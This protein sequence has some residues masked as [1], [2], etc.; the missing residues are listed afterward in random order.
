[1]S[2]ALPQYWWILAITTVAFCLSAFGNGA[3]DVANAFATSVAAR[4]LTMAQAGVI[5]VIAEFLGAVVLGSR[6]TNTIKN[7]IIGLDRFRDNPATLLVAMGSAEIASATWLLVATKIGFPVSTTH[8]IVGALVGAGIGA[9]SAVTWEWKKG[10][11]SQIAASWLISPLIAA[12]FS[13]ILFGTLKFCVL[14]RKD[15]FKKALRAIPFYLAF[16][17]AI[18]ALFITIEAPGA[19]SLEE[20]GVGVACGI[21]FGAFFGVLALSYLFFM[22][23]F[24]RVVVLEDDRMRPWHLPLGPLLWRENPPLYFPGKTTMLVDHYESAHNKETATGTQPSASS[25]KASATDAET[26][27]PNSQG[28]KDVE[29]EGQVTRDIERQPEEPAVR[30]APR[31]PEPEERFL[32][33]TAHLPFYHPRRMKS[34]ILYFL[35]QGVTRDCVIHDSLHLENVHGRAP[36]YDNRIE[37][38]WTYAQVASAVMMSIS[39]GSNDVANAVG[40]WVAVYE[41]YNSG[42]VGEENPTPVW[43]LAIAGLLL[44]AGF[45]FMGHHIVKALG[46]KITQLSP[47]RGYAMELGAAITVLLASRLGLPV[48]TTQTLTGAV[49]G[50]SL[51]NLDFGATNWKQLGFIFIGWVLTLPCVATLAGVLTA[52]SLSSPSFN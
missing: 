9:Q 3:N 7:G 14:E 49:V 44:G 28:P 33:P 29:T 27:L 26:N 36:R 45:W 23:Y 35:L 18:L 15:A 43:I 1:M 6:V 5:S 20:L 22:P 50:V 19:P 25:Q 8:T 30:R 2:P 46:N 38:L 10:S 31:K 32:A 34:L 12:A 16:T 21:V 41:T 39:H 52:M 51:M 47:T 37:H 4:T 42:K 17:G 48:S 24:H 13:A 11:V 40:P